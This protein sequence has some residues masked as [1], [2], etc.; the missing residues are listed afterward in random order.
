MLVFFFHQLVPHWSPISCVLPSPG[1][2]GPSRAE[3][4]VG[5][6]CVR[7][8]QALPSSRL[9]PLRWS[10]SVSV[11]PPLF[12]S[13][14]LSGFA[15]FGPGVL[16]CVLSLFFCVPLFA[17]WL[18]NLSSHFHVHL[19]FIPPFILI[20]TSF[21]M[22]PPC[23]RQGVCVCVARLY[24]RK[25][26]YYNIIYPNAGGSPGSRGVG[27]QRRHFPGTRAN[28]PAGLRWCTWAHLS[29]SWWPP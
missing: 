14:A 19:T 25:T 8:V 2:S 4:C 5:F 29:R 20:F 18:S 26:S 22:A 16:V 13:L 24:R 12:S 15:R 3:I 10:C 1:R 23:Q 17:F 21:S 27:D 7:L 11:G 9:P 6:C 28:V